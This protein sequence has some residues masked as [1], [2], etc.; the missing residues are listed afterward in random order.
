MASLRTVRRQQFNGLIINPVYMRFKP[1]MLVK[2]EKTGTLEDV[3][4]QD[5]IQD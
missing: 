2:R 3:G 1:Q 5:L 4:A